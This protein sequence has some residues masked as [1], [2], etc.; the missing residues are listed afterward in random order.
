MG[1][2]KTFIKQRLGFGYLAQIADISK[3]DFVGTR[4]FQCWDLIDKRLGFRLTDDQLNVLITLLI[5]GDDIYYR[6]IERFT[7]RTNLPSVW[8]EFRFLHD[9]AVLSDFM[10]EQCPDPPGLGYRPPTPIPR[11]KK[12]PVFMAESGEAS[13][14]IG[15]ETQ[16][17]SQVD[18]EQ[19]MKFVDNQ[20]IMILDMST[21]FDSTR[22]GEDYQGVTSLGAFLERPI[23]LDQFDWT[24]GGNFDSTTNY[25]DINPWFSYLNDPGIKYKVNN[26]RM[27]RADGM[28]IQF[29]LNGSPFHYGQLYAGYCP[30]KYQAPYAGLKEPQNQVL[31]ATNMGTFNA[32]TFPLYTHFS[33]WPGVFINPATNVVA[34]LDIP[35]F[36]PQNYL[37]TVSSLDF[38][39]MGVLKIWAINALQHSNGATDKITLT[40]TA[41]LINPI[42]TMPTSSDAF[43]GESGVGDTKDVTRTRREKE[44]AKT[45]EAKPKKQAAT[46]NDEYGKGAISAPAT[47]LANFA[48]TLDRVPV[49]GPYALA[50]RLA[51]GKVAAV[52][53]IFGYSRPVNVESECHFNYRSY[54]PLALT[55]AEDTSHK[56][57]LDPKQ[58]VT[59]DPVTVGLRNIDEMTFAHIF[60]RE[61]LIIQFPWTIAD[62]QDANLVQILVNPYNHPA[63]VGTET[64][65]F[66]TALSWGVSPF[67]FWRGSLRYRFQI[68]A[69]QMHRGRLAI[70]YSPI[71][72]GSATLPHQSQTFQQFIDLAET[73]DVTVEVAYA[74]PNPWLQ[75]I[76]PNNNFVSKGQ[77]VFTDAIAVTANGLLQ[78]YVLN[79]LTSPTNTSSVTVNVFVSAGDDFMV[80]E[81]G[82]T[83]F[84]KMSPYANV[85]SSN[86]TAESGVADFVSPSESVPVQ[87]RIIKI[88]GAE[89]D[90]PDVDNQC[91]VF[92]GEQAVSLR[93]LLKRYCY[94]TPR[95]PFGTG[96]TGKVGY[97]SFSHSRVP[98][99][100]GL[101]DNVA[102]ESLNTADALGPYNY[103]RTT[104][105][106]W[107]RRGY[108]AN[109]GAIRWKYI[110]ITYATNTNIIGTMRAH[111]V[112]SS[113]TP[114]LRYLAD[115]TDDIYGP[116]DINGS[117][118]QYES[119]GA[120]TNSFSGAE[121]EFQRM[122]NGIEYEHPWYSSQRFE[123]N[124]LGPDLS[125]APDPNDAYTYQFQVV[126][127]STITVDLPMGA[128]SVDDGA[129]GM[130]LWCAAGEDFC[131]H[132]FLGAP[133]VGFTTPS[134]PAT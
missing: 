86:Y 10:E 63:N 87:K 75:I 79:E 128:G 66:H 20:D 11:S 112:T 104:L 91:V 124:S 72:V 116:N 28:R 78:V 99:S 126:A 133:V 1:I 118:F 17:S 2:L 117:A 60:K 94:Y 49:I 85:I 108:V 114:A 81:P 134:N 73:R 76:A 45:P 29:R 131:L 14:K 3:V 130:E 96:T 103:I 9:A 4:L 8:N 69:S 39:S 82:A 59:I 129:A 127:R 113:L 93:S 30:G 109:R 67:V 107:F 13:V 125:T 19:T 132:Y 51:L 47:A 42:L 31:L 22:I 43:V 70:V 23:I 71:C 33:Q 74:H 55:T 97:M 7:Q 115:F 15:E 44:A 24:P 38:I 83:N 64:V 122:K 101:V 35:F 54:G 92:F 100:R 32:T 40:V 25:V 41:H 57:T 105:I 89:M 119:F 77:V 27:L 106:D 58:E 62:S 26:Y 21:P 123:W 61:S 56:L 111:R 110:P 121:F 36:W 120:M 98:Q 46:K 37:N 95:I 65:D 52:A 5:Y 50:T 88:N 6:D 18:E 84:D 16:V 53:K 68:I 48:G 102:N 80:G 90:T 12:V 34:E